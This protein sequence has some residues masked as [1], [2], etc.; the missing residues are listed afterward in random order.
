MISR[1]TSITGSARHLDENDLWSREIHVDV[2]C[3][4]CAAWQYLPYLQLIPEGHNQLYRLLAIQ[5]RSRTSVLSL[6]PAG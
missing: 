4:S 5:L 6:R 1:V 2:Y 3:S